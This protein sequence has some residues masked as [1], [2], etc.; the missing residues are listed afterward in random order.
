MLTRIFGRKKYGKTSFCINKIKECVQQKKRCLFIVPEQFTFS[1]EKKIT[2]EIGNCA[3]M[4]VEVLS[5]TRLCYRVFRE[6]GGVSNSYLDS[7]GKVLCMTKVL[8]EFGDQL[9]EYGKSSSDISFASAAVHTAEEFSAYNISSSMIDNALAELGDEHG[10]LCSKLKDVS[11]L[12]AAYKA[13]LKSIYGTDGECLDALCDVLRSNNFFK[14]V[15]VILDSFYG[16]TPKELSIIRF[17]LLQSHDVNI[18]FCTHRDDC[19]PVFKRPVEAS[20]QIMRIAAENN[21]QVDDICLEPPKYDDDISY[22]ERNFTCIR[23]E[24]DPSDIRAEGKNISIIQCK[25]PIDEARAVCSVIYQLIS[26]GARF[27]DIAICARN[28]SSYEG[29]IDVFLEKV[30][31]PFTFSVKEDLLTKPIISYIV[32]S[33][34]FISGWKQQSFLYLLK[35]GLVRLSSEQCALLESYIRTWNINGKKEFLTDWFMNPAG[36]VEGFTDHDSYVLEQVNLSKETVMSALIKFSEDISAAHTCREVA[37]AVY[38][39]MCDSSYAENFCDGD[40]RFWNLTVN[41]LDAIVKVYG[42][43]EIDVK[44]FT[45]IF[46][47]V[48]NEYGVQDIPDTVDSVLIG[49]IDLIRSETIKY[50]FVLGC[51]NEY[52]PMQKSQDAIFTDSEKGILKS[53]GISVSPAAIDCAYDEYFLAYNIFCDPYEKLFL[54]YSSADTEG[55]ALR[56][57]VLLDTVS[58]MFL[59]S[60]EVSYPFEDAVSNI[61]CAA[62]LADDMYIYGDKT[63]VS[64][65][66]SVLSEDPVYCDVF[67]KTSCLLNPDGVLSHENTKK[68]FGSTVCSSPS[69]FEAYSRCRFM[70]FNRYLLKLKTE[71]KAEL[72]SVN[73]GLVSH[74]ILELFVKELAESKLSGNLFTHERASERVKELLK[75]H[76][77]GI[78]HITDKDDTGV[79]KRFK[80]LYNR[81]YNIL[82]AL[83]VHLVDELAQSEFIPTDFEVNIGITDDTIKSVPIDI[84]DADGNRV[85]ELR[86]VGQVDRTDVYHKDGNTYVRIID[87]KTGHKAFRKDE[88]DYGF[89]LQMLLYLYCIAFSETKRY[90]Q[91]VVPAGV[92]YIPVRR[93][94]KRDAHLYDSTE[95]LSSSELLKAFK[96]DGILIDNI[97]ILNAMDDGITGKFIPAVMRKDKLDARS[98]IDSLENM[99]ALLK[100]AADVSGKL[101]SLMYAGN[102]QANPYKVAFSSCE[103]CD[104]KSVCRID[105]KNDNIRYS[106]EEVL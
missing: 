38:R 83:A 43:E 49:S 74:K 39:L 5:F 82:S 17:M 59:S 13:E 104:Y 68:L 50:M 36:Y 60:L 53:V 29:I 42:D 90:G 95:D 100:K 21:V 27:R 106:M 89:N 80:Y 1:A 18:T 20:Q 96:G 93:P 62:A 40:E 54:L 8:G 85:G 94:E 23:T 71:V 81:L 69:R 88:V 56:K 77:E 72:D 14:D 61:T 65:A 25:N 78:T 15:C 4:Y 58:D 99:G 79:S 97:D 103:Y 6:L 30:E 46:R 87:Y 55:K 102:I 64:V 70:Y 12:S 44:R 33:L 16:Y 91:N 24:F 11:L 28:I 10:N 105:R 7:V 51:N 63:F 31:V 47:T 37:A 57:S 41:A 48:I 19:D 101:A 52:F 2:D 3:N 45:D 84:H 76:F 26:A 67:E 86:I 35:T 75:L 92:L 34:E 9:Y 73:T 22:I 32:T 66:K 98:K